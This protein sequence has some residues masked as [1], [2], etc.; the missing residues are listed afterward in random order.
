MFLI[1]YL[2]TSVCNLGDVT[3]ITSGFRLCMLVVCP[4]LRMQHVTNNQNFYLDSHRHRSG[5]FIA[6]VATVTC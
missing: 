6:K 2:R 4:G 1:P 3:Q 5:K